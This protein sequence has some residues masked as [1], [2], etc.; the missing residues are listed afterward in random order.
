MT[1]TKRNWPVIL[2]VALLLQVG[3]AF[4]MEFSGAGEGGSQGTEPLLAFEADRIDRIEIADDETK[5]SL[6]KV[7]ETWQLPELADFP[8]DPSAVERILRRLGEIRRGWPVASSS[9]AAERFGVTEDTAE[10]TIAL[11]AGEEEVAKL[12]VGTSPGFRKVHVRPGGSDDIYDVEFNTFEASEKNDDWIAKD[13]LQQD[14]NQLARIEWGD[15]VVTRNGDQWTLPDLT[16]EE[17]PSDALATLIRKLVTLRISSVLGNE[18]KPE[19]RL[20]EPRIVAVFY[21]ADG[22]PSKLALSQRA[23]GGDY[24]VKAS[25][26]PQLMELP[27][28]LVDEISAYDRAE[29]VR[30]RAKSDATSEEADPGAPA[31]ESAA[32]APEPSTDD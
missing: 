25:D 6:R 12:L 29:L 32:D 30:P 11:F 26:R 3:L 22:E 23:E 13:V 7:G 14:E 1:M 10:R 9:S 19:Y 20:D 5:V 27:A 4:A 18:A 2:A 15:L 28:S 17:E 21:P 24:I 31:A 8:A 16:A